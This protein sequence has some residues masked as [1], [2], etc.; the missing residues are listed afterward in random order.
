M[1]S[2]YVWLTPNATDIL[3]EFFEIEKLPSVYAWRNLIYRAAE[4]SIGGEG[5]GVKT[6]RKTW[7]SWLVVAGYDLTLIALSQGHTETTML[8]HYLQLPF[9]EEEKAE[10]KSRVAGWGKISLKVV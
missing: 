7:E 3:P 5:V 8:N 9:T 10:I 4:R 1:K 2:R 6:T